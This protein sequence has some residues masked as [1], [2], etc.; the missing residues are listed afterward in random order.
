MARQT[1]RTVRIIC[2]G[3]SEEHFIKHVRTLYLQR[4]GNLE[5]STKNAHGKGARNALRL[6]LSPRVRLGVDDI[7]ILVDTDTDWDDAQRKIAKQ[8]K[9]H[10]LE[11]DPCLEAWLLSTAGHVSTGDSKERKRIFHK[12]FGSHAQDEIVYPRHFGKSVLDAA[13]GKVRVLNQLLALIGV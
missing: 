1:R 4:R 7:A 6:A 12:M 5:L 3:Y 2:E 13:R 8:R 11:S 10:V 9:I